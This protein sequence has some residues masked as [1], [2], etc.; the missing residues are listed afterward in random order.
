MV[1][2][3]I[4]LIVA[5]VLATNA[6]LTAKGINPIPF[7]ANAF[8]ETASQVANGLGI[9]WVWWK[10]NNITSASQ[11]A[12][13]VLTSIKQGTYELENDATAESDN[14]DVAVTN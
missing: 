10:N 6:Y 3:I 12:Q 9:V 1:K 8:T 14:E 4:R 7:D 11:T 13:S 2:A 5:A